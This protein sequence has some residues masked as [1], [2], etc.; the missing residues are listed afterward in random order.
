MW[1]RGRLRGGGARN[2]Q[3]AA[4]LLMLMQKINN[5][6]RKPPLTLGLMGTLALLLKSAT[7]FSIEACE[8]CCNAYQD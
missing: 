4:L 3:N 2:G 5:L 6:D 1:G 7:L 8:C